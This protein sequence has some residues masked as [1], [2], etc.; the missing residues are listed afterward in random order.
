MAVHK[1]NLK[2]LLYQLISI[3]E[4]SIKPNQIIIVIDSK[5]PESS[6]RSIDKV[7]KDYS[8]ENIIVKTKKNQGYSNAF[9]YGLT[10]VKSDIVY[11]ADQDD[12]W[13]RNKIEVTHK[14]LKSGVCDAVINNCQFYWE[15]NKK[16]GPTK[17]K[18]INKKY[19]C[20]SPFIAGC[21][22]AITRRVSDLMLEGLFNYLE[23]DEQAHLIANLISRRK[24]ILDNLQM[25][26]RH[27]SNSSLN[28][29]NSGILQYIHFT[30][31]LRNYL[32][33]LKV[34]FLLWNNK[35]YNYSL[36]KTYI[37][38]SKLTKVQFNP[39][40][41]NILK[42]WIR[43][44]INYHNQSTGRIYNFLII[45]LLQ[46]LY[47][48]FRLIL[49]SSKDY[50]TV[51]KKLNNKLIVS[52]LSLDLFH[53]WGG[54]VFSIMRKGQNS[55]IIYDELE[56][57]IT[58]AADQKRPLLLLRL[59]DGEFKLLIGLQMLGK[60][61]TM[62]NRLG[63]LCRILNSFFSRKTEISNTNYSG[64]SQITT[65]LLKKIRHK[66]WLNI[67]NY[68][69]KILLCAHLSW[70]NMSVN[71]T[72]YINKFLDVFV[73]IDSIKVSEMLYPFYFVYAIISNG[74]IFSNKRIL[75]ISS[76]INTKAHRVSESLMKKGVTKVKHYR[77]SSEF[78]YNVSLDVTSINKFD[79]D[80]VL[81]GAGVFKLVLIPQ[82]VTIQAPVLDAGYMLE[83]L[84]SK[85]LSLS[86]P[87]CN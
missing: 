39:I 21:C 65:K 7:L 36:V 40:T 25:Y 37:R 66:S 83:V 5:L 33:C 78:T 26:R 76:F 14:Y 19:G 62:K 60:G 53:K 22:T 30:D 11:F 52:R 43:A 64:N 44:I 41:G 10:F 50:I 8:I 70:S 55:Q 68:N 27:N 18:I 46:N 63:I 86:R 51:P 28:D 84:S 15:K 6:E 79:P 87:Y 69:S 74:K 2:N 13:N 1:P 72:P 34:N 85:D 71:Q 17:A 49:P 31:V 12:I 73:K 57:R 35:N 16:F 47:Y 3:L 56:Y 67:K 48:F 82:L 54:G 29:I 38:I 81:F 42:F 61:L 32:L 24:I 45:I 58:L 75:V 59:S 23:Y 80:I 77:I 4:Q 9:R 20:Y